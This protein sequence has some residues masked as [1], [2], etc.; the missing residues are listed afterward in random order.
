[1][2]V[3][4][5]M[6]GLYPPDPDHILGG[7]EAVTYHLTHALS[8]FPDLDI[9]AV[10]FRPDLKQPRRVEHG[11]VRVHLFP[12]PR[13]DRL[14]WR[15]P[16]VRVLRRALQY[17]QPDVV[18]AHGTTMYAAAAVSSP[19]PH[20][21]TVHGIMAREAP[22][23]WG[24]R[25]RLAREVDRW[26][27]R[28]VLKRTREV[29]AISPYVP[30]AYPWLRARFH[31]IENPVDPRFFDAPMDGME[32][33]NVLCVARVIPRKGVL[34]LI[35]AFARVTADVPAA[36]LHIA[37][38]TNSFPEYAAACRNEA[39]RLG[40]ASRVH[41]LGPL[42][43]DALVDAYARAQV[44]ALAS[45]QETAPVVIAEA[46]AAGRP[47]V[48]TAVG[49]VPYMVQ[50]GKTGWLVPPEDEKALVRAL[51]TALTSP[52]MCRKMGEVARADA[53]ARFHPLPLAEKHVDVYRS[54]IREAGQAE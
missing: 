35:R 7:V 6:L 2:T 33:G 20:V 48:A 12:T 14:F 39:R 44:V 16:S 29:I 25:R 45:L 5:A 18:H 1:M 42:G 46:L 17:L 41:F 54:L 4:V 10:S 26:F 49:G 11:R 28:W 8:T 31:F 19:F 15:R 37:G 53:R 32:V 3:R 50:E 24:W 38:E 47:V 40:V 27:E 30:Q 21:V 23:V 36:E 22:T 43:M 13:N 52:E 9:H 34:T 51:T